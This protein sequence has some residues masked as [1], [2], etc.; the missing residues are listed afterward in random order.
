M[1]DFSMAPACPRPEVVAAVER[2]IDGLV[3]PGTTWDGDTRRAIALE[4]RAKRLGTDS[5]PYVSGGLAEPVELLAR[6][7]AA[8]SQ[9]W[10]ERQVDRL[11]LGGY[12]EALG[13][14]S[15]TVAIDTFHR[16]L[17][18]PAPDLPAAQPGPPTGDAAAVDEGPTWIP[19]GRVPI[20]PTVL[21]AVPAE[22][23]AQN[24]LSD[25]LYMTGA[26]MAD[27]DWQRRGMHRAQ[28]ELGA[29]AL[30]H[31]NECFF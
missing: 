30:S 18:S 17:G 9:A 12:L 24:V 15:R 7:P 13:V 26:E 16:M 1:L 19:A 2:S 29:S 27:P 8:A 25:V 22:V 31:G 6:R 5:N 11:G 23:E 20:P 14:V 28:A 4:A 21:A 3:G 10:V